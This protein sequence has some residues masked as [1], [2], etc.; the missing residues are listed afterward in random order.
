MTEPAAATDLADVPYTEIVVTDAGRQA[1]TDD[2]D[3]TDEQREILAVLVF[4]GR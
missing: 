1:I 3:L 2:P 4:L